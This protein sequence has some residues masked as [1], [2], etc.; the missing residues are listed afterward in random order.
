MENNH[1]EMIK[2][3]EE[4]RSTQDQLMIGQDKFK[5]TTYQLMDG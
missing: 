3:T 2:A 5:S 4:L 1:D